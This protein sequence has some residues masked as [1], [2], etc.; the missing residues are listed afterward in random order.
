[1]FEERIAEVSLKEVVN[2]I[3]F[4]YLSQID[5]SRRIYLACYPDQFLR[6]NEKKTSAEE[7][8]GVVGGGRRKRGW[9]H[10]DLSPVLHRFSLA[11]G[12]LILVPTN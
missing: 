6:T 10:S 3:F 9:A 11:L 4:S 2:L 12:F 5:A 1:M 7:K 8:E